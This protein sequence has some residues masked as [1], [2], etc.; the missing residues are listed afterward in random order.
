MGERINW[1]GMTNADLAERM[2]NALDVLEGAAMLTPDALD[3]FREA[4]TRIEE[5]PDDE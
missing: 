4:Q 5:T 1:P 2:A 3:A